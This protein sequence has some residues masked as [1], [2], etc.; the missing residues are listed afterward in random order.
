VQGE[1]LDAFAR[2]CFP[3]MR[4][5]DIG[6]HYGFFA[7]ACLKYGSRDSQVLCVEASPKATAILRANLVLNGADSQVSVVNCAMGATDGELQMLTTGPMGG[8]YFVVPT[9]ARNDT[10]PVPQRSLPSLVAEREFEMTHVK[11]DI[12]SFEYEVVEA[13]AE[14]LQRVLPIFFLELHGNQ[15]SAR[16]KNPEKV[17]ETLSACGYRRFLLGGEIVGIRQMAEAGF[18]CRLVCL[19]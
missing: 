13:G 7:L 1:E 18:N 8:D 15:L 9:E 2:H 10:Q 19:P 6:A 5:L 4:L 17:I 3:G 14:L 16:G 12:E 11:M